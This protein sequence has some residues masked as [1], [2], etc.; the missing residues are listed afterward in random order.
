MKGI[1]SLIVCLILAAPSWGQR[2]AQPVLFIPG[3]LGTKLVDEKG[4][5]VCCDPVQFLLRLDDLE[6]PQNPQENKLQAEEIIDQL[7]LLG[8]FKVNQ[9]NGLLQIFAKLGFEEGRDLFVFPYD[10][11]LSNFHTAAQLRQFIDRH[12][13]L[14][15]HPFR[16]VG[17]SMGG[18]VARIFLH[19]YGQQYT[20]SSLITMGTPHLG[21][22]RALQA[23]LEGF[24]ETLNLIPGGERITRVVGSFQSIYE[25]LPTYENCC[26]LNSPGTTEKKS[27]DITDI[28]LWRQ[29]GWFSQFPP[30]HRHYVKSRL[31]QVVRL[32]QIMKTRPPAQTQI[33]K[34][35]GSNFSTP[36]RVYLN[37]PGEPLEWAEINGDETVIEY[38]AANGDWAGTFSAIESHDKIFNDEHVKILLRR[39]LT[40]NTS[41]EEFSQLLEDIQK[42]PPTDSLGAPSLTRARQIKSQTSSSTGFHSTGLV[43]REATPRPVPLASLKLATQSPYL[44][45]GAQSWVRIELTQPGPN[46]L[47]PQRNTAPIEQVRIEGRLEAPQDTG[48]PLQFN[49]IHPGIYEALFTVPSAPAMYRIAVRI[50]GLGTFEEHFVVVARPDQKP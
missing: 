10:W 21:S 11:R 28:D 34:I 2:P 29:M 44:D 50:P 37:A 13:P 38:S 16:I 14:R 47:L 27:V 23:L 3:F 9:Y 46:A 41:L 6:L 4:E 1:Y 25:L 40:R 12:P 42:T 20:V 5:L 31:V 7:I 48:Q 18:L 22:L 17:H 43:Q 45:P 36:G 32:R 19:E 15:D 24:G 35:V 49:E 33:F 26:I 39:L 8:P 30:A